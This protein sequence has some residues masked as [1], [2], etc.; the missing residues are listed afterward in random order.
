MHFRPRLF[1]NPIAS[2]CMSQTCLSSV[3]GSWGL[4]VAIWISSSI[5]ILKFRSKAI[6]DELHVIEGTSFQLVKRARCSDIFKIFGKLSAQ[7]SISFFKA[8]GS[9]MLSLHNWPGS[10]KR[11]MVKVLSW[12]TVGVGV[13]N[14][15]ILL[16][17]VPWMPK[18]LYESGRGGSSPSPMYTRQYR[19]CPR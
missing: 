19:F 1:Y 16:S 2:L 17:N 12:V 8:N 15:E 10:R 4:S 11:L 5:L 18:S 9:S 7:D 3:D 14:S 6:F 13:V